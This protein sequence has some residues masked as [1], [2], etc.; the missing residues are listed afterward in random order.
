MKRQKVDEETNAE[1]WTPST[2]CH[3]MNAW[4]D[5]V[6]HEMDIPEEFNA[7]LD[8]LKIHLLSHSAEQISRN[9]AL[10]LYSATRHEQARKIN[11]ED[12]WNVS[13]HNI[14]YLPQVIT[15]Q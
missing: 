1:M 14:N 10:Q 8:I 6:S 13:N 4:Q 5:Y 11:L 3:K 7:D 2:K 15:F 9:G 12:G